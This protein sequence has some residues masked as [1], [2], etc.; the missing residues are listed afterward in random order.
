MPSLPLFDLE[1]KKLG[2]VELEDAIFASEVK[3]HLLNEAVR[4]QVAKRY[5]HRTA[6]SL[7]RT[8]VHGTRKK[9][10]K[11][12][13]TGQARHG[14]KK[15]PIFVGGGKSHGPKPRMVVRKMNK[16][17]MK[18]ALVSALSQSQ[19]SDKLFVVD[20]LECKKAST[21]WIA[22]RLQQFNEQ[23]VL[24]INENATD[25]QKSFNL[26]TRNIRGV[27]HLRPEGLN[28]FDILKYRTLVISQ[29]ALQ[30]LTERLKHV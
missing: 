18:G 30:K 22:K 29:G 4:C 2:S 1:K 25:S 12:K 21:N 14:D 15:A 27:K 16:K 10:Y 8:E 5:E 23:S 19:K 24:V 6:N 7:T 11:Q 13:G 20:K 3:P 26:G 9:M 28:V 17:A